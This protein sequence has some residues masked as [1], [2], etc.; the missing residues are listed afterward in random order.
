MTP[1]EIKRYLELPVEFRDDYLNRSRDAGR[2]VPDEVAERLAIASML[3]GLRKRGC[4]PELTYA[5]VSLV[6]CNFFDDDSGEIV[7]V[8]GE[9]DLL[10]LLAACEHVAKAVQ[11]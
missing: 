6:G 9:S 4:D 5:G 2:H 3:V 8:D 7:R 10:A 11:P 1:E